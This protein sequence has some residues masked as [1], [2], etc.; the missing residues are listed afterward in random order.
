[1]EY[2]NKQNTH[3]TGDDGRL[4]DFDPIVVIRDVLKRWLF[5][6]LAAIMVGVGTYIATD[7]SYTPSYTATTT[8]VV[9]AR[10]SSS[11]IYSN[12]STT[13]TLASVFEELLNSSLLRK[14]I[15]AEIGTSSFDGTI[16]ASIIPETNLI[17]VRVT[18]S[19]PRTAFLVSQAI[20]D[21][22][23]ELT[24]QIL[25][26]TSLEVL[27][28]PAIPT[29][30]SNSTNAMEQMKRMAVMAAGATAALLAVLS[31]CRKT[32]RSEYEATK[33]LGCDCLGEIP[34]ENK[35]KTILSRLSRRK[36]SI[37]I[38]NPAT[39]FRYVESIRKL[40]R[41]V[42]R[43][44]HGRKVIMVT[45]LQENEGKST[46]SVNLALSLAQKNQRVILV[47]CDFRK[48]A[49]HAILDM[50]SVPG[51]L[52]DVLSGQTALSDAIVCDK[53]SRLHLLLEQRPIRT[54]GDLISSAN[55]NALLTQL[56]RK[57]DYIVL[58][59]PPMAAVSD[60]ESMMEYADASLL[61]VRQNISTVP[62]LNKA[63][64]ALAM[65]QA[66]LLG[67]VVNNVHSTGLISGQDYDYGYGTRHYGHYSS[68]KSK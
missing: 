54:S 44:M 18:A 23:E 1:M 22:H 65:G 50:T 56:R 28:A 63:I 15:L 64:T 32:V 29:A 10:G 24:Y 9:T 2:Q 8:Y 67:C 17:N 12:L 14:T 68:K 38:S 35:H 42:E 43:R 39:N 7:I 19:D 31:F 51:Q 34:H 5:I 57:Y 60:A 40:R 48:P 4:L 20:I 47:D 53:K 61:V 21:H 46:V 62:A 11:T 41:R 16:S 26:A 30:P 49:C 3:G 52:C 27:Q 37:L 45:S 55:M 66:K 25:D 6:L 58:D 59:L 13:T 33:V 36:T